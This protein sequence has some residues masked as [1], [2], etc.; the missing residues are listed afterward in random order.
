VPCSRWVWQYICV[1]CRPVPW[2]H[3][4]LHAEAD[5]FTDGSRCLLAMCRDLGIAGGCQQPR[6]TY[7][8]YVPRSKVLS[9]Q[10]SQRLELVAAAT[11]RFRPRKCP[12]VETTAKRGGAAVE[13]PRQALAA[14]VAVIVAVSARP[15]NG[16]SPPGW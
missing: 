15:Q 13:W 4:W 12:S 3:F 2:L 9:G 5:G 14:A 10:L 16:C 1:R 7:P 8:A 11:V 6:L